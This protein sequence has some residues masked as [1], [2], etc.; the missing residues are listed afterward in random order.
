MRSQARALESILLGG[1][2][3]N[4]GRSVMKNMCSTSGTCRYN[5]QEA[6]KQLFYASMW[7]S[8]GLV[9]VEKMMHVLSSEINFDALLL[10]V[11]EFI[12]TC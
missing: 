3:K 6:L 12:V 10:L 1:D 7:N 8:K 9:S 4:L 5:F 2:K 11:K